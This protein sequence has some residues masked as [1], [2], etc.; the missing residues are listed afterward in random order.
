ME[1]YDQHYEDSCLLRTSFW[2]AVGKLEEDVI[3][4]IINP[5]FMGGPM[6][7]SVRQAFITVHRPDSTILASDGLSDPYDDMDTNP[8]NAPYNGFGLETYIVTEPLT[9]PVQSTWQFQLVYQAAQLMADNGSVASMLDKQPYISTEFYN[10]DVPA[11]F[12]NA[13]GRVGAMLGIS[14]EGLP[15]GIELSLETIK[16]VNVKLLTQAELK[17]V[18]DNGQEGRMKL[19]ALLKEQGNGG[20]SSLQRP[21]VV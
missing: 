2:Q 10:V 5:A 6:W 21:S 4:H 11:E 17:Y 20:F 16:L 8:D 19:A 9:G 12:L 3:A 7:P 13:D 18:I 15:A 14:D 1:T